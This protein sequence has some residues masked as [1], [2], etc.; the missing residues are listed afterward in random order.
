MLSQL[1]RAASRRGLS[2]AAARRRA[3]PRICTPT[4]SFH[5]S[6]PRREPRCAASVEGAGG[7]HRGPRV[8]G[9]R[10]AAQVVQRPAPPLVDVVQGRDAGRA[11]EQRHAPEI[12]AAQGGRAQEHGADQGWRS[13]RKIK[14]AELTS[15][16]RAPASRRRPRGLEAH[17]ASRLDNMRYPCIRLLAKGLR[18][19]NY[20]AT[21][22]FAAA[23]SGRQRTRALRPCRH[24]HEQH[25]C[26]A[27]SPRVP[28]RPTP[29]PESTASWPGSRATPRRRRT[30]PSRPAT[31]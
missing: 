7:R 22:A 27:S 21:A 28:R 1:A 26:S 12:P 15:Q 29:S 31:T 16:P 14:A 9:L 11:G 17:Y 25:P 10:A 8:G 19:V 2:R 18:N 6:G 20:G 24:D 3:A 4:A 13:A 23:L 5:A 30:G